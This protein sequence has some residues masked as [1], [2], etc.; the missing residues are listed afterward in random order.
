MK[1]AY[2]QPQTATI[3][4]SYSFVI[5]IPDDIYRAT[6]CGAQLARAH[7][8]ARLYC[9]DIFQLEIW[10]QKASSCQESNLAPDIV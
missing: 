6:Y 2:Q 10:K 8:A 1:T 9:K 7:F 3:I 4:S 5:S